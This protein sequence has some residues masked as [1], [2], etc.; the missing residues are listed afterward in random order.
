MKIVVKYQYSDGKEI[1][2]TSS[3]LDVDR[4]SNK[5]ITREIEK[6]LS[7]S[8]ELLIIEKITALKQDIHLHSI[9]AERPIEECLRLL[10]D[11]FILLNNTSRISLQGQ[12]LRHRLG[13]FLS[14][15]PI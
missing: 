15:S 4:I 6:T 8:E 13:R 14:K 5:S 1:S 7:S 12:E 9:K 11:C 2:S 3:I 10:D